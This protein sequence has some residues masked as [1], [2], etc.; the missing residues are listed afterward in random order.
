M[1]LTRSDYWLARFCYQFAGVMNWLSSIENQWLPSEAIEKPIDR[2]IYITGLARAGSTVL[3]E[4]ISNAPKIG[5]HRYCDFPF[6]ATPWLWNKYRRII[7]SKPNQIPIERPHRDK[8]QITPNSP[9]SMEEPLWQSWFPFVHDMNS[10]H[11]IPI[12]TSNPRFARFYREHINKVLLIRE[13]DRYAAKNNY[14]LTRIEYLLQLFPDARFVIPVRHP[15]SHVDSLSRQHELFCRYAKDD[16]RIGPYLQAAGHYE[17]GPQRVPVHLQ[18]NSIGEIRTAL[19]KGQDHVAYAIQW[20]DIYAKPLALLT[21]NPRFKKQ[22]TFVKHEDFCNDP[23]AAWKRIANTCDLDENPPDL[24]HIVAPNTKLRLTDI[25]E[26][27]IWNI[28]GEIAE[29]LGYA[30]N[31]ISETA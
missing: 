11:E 19:R 13:A 17:F 29:E 27:E 2:P 6:V 20:R 31:G 8:I 18:Q 12:S 5:T 14:H 21:K 22:I 28:A 25:Q 16:S 7:S 10:V 1:Q 3:L 9:E 15:V 4:L 23:Y 26:L 24:K 30:A